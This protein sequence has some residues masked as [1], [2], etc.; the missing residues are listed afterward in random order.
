MTENPPS[1]FTKYRV[2]YP[3]I[4]I[5]EASGTLYGETSPDGVTWTNGPGSTTVGWSYASG[6]QLSLG[7]AIVPSY[8]TP[9]YPGYAQFDQVAVQ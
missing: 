2:P 1:F 4:R 3:Q 7:V 8:T 9:A 6:V 5:R